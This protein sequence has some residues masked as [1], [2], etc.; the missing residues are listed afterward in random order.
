MTRTIAPHASD[1]L[2]LAA[3]AVASAALAPDDPVLLFSASDLSQVG[4]CEAREALMI[5]AETIAVRA[6]RSPGEDDE[7]LADLCAHRL[8]KEMLR[9]GVPAG[10]SEGINAVAVLNAV[11]ALV[12]AARRSDCPSPWMALG[13]RDLRELDLARSDPSPV[14]L[15]APVLW[16]PLGGIAGPWA[17]AHALARERVLAAIA[18]APRGQVATSRPRA[19]LRAA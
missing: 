4:A 15:S 5:P 6:P 18:E 13:A 16:I 10:P 19:L 3:A 11:A 1:R 14:L 8:R 2:E 9:A 12:A 7:Y 17:D